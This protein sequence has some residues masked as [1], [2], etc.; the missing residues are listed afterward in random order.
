MAHILEHVPCPKCGSR[1]NVG[2]YSDGSEWC[3]GACGY[4]KPPAGMARIRNVIRPN[5]SGEASANGDIVLPS[6][7]TY[8]L[9][10]EHLSWL[11]KYGITTKEIIN[12]R[13]MSSASRGLILP[14]FDGQGKYLKFFINRPM[15]VGHP[16][17]IDNGKKP[18]V[19][20]GTYENTKHPEVVVLVE[21][22]ISAIKV[23]RQFFCVPLFGSMVS[24]DVILK[25]QK[26]FK[27]VV[28]WLD[29][30]KYI[31]SVR[32]MLRYGHVMN[33]VTVKSEQDPKEHSDRDIF[34]FISEAIE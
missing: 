26:K 25:L 14:I 10:E 11:R 32:T 9:Q 4:Y 19:L 8:R 28:Y 7:A 34:K 24:A 31:H 15:M 2:R 16:K 23:S 5:P 6:D 3:F 17:S 13:I 29:P 33:S 20:F 21:D 1:D 12:Y 22:Y 18:M 30:D 27:T